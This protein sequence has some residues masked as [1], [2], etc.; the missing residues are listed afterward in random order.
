MLTICRA[1][2][3]LSLVTTA[4]RLVCSIVHSNYSSKFV[5]GNN[6]IAIQADTSC[7]TFSL[8]Q[9][10]CQPKHISSL[11]LSR[12]LN[13]GKIHIIDVCLTLSVSFSMSLGQLNF[14]TFFFVCTDWL[15]WRLSFRKY[16]YTWLQRR[17]INETEMQR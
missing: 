3:T 8:L 2:C 12:Q 11:V 13:R 7:C 5:T 15:Q 4:L 14:W 17:N 6:T 16:A 1:N 9:C 10:V